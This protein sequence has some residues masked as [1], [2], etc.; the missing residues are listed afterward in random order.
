M[1]HKVLDCI[2][3]LCGVWVI[4]LVAAC[5]GQAHTAMCGGMSRA[6]LGM[7]CITQHRM[8]PIG[9]LGVRVFQYCLLLLLAG[10][11][12]VGNAIGSS[13]VMCPGDK[14]FLW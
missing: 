2:S 12:L 9:P 14:L 6:V 13:A 5:L 7:S 8:C 4:L 10:A 3:C 11:V 1:S